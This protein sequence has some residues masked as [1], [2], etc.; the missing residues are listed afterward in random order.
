MDRR[1]FIRNI[2]W[3]VAAAATGG[4]AGCTQQS[5]EQTEMQAETPPEEKASGIKRYTAIG[6]TDL[7]MSDISMGCGGLD[8]VYV[9]DKALDVGINYFDTAPDYGNGNSESTLGKV[10]TESSKRQKAI[11]TTKFCERGPYGLHLEVNSPEEKYI[12]AVEGSLKRLNTDYIDFEMVHAIGERENDAARL[13]DS[14]MLSAYTKL[15][16]QGKVRYLSVSSHG[17][18]GMEEHLDA[19]ID[20]G[21]FDMI[22]PALN[23]ARFSRLG[24]ILAKAQEKGVGVVAMKT[25]ASAKQED[26]SRFE[27]ED[28]DLAQAAFKWVFAQPGITG[29]IITMKHTMDVEKYV[30]ASGKRFTPADQSLLDHYLQSIGHTYCRT[31]CGECLAA[32]PHAVAIPEILRYDM[33]FTAYREEDMALRSFHRLP[34]SQK[35]IPCENCIGSCASGCPYGLPVRDQLL[36]ASGRLQMV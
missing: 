32:C 6:N 5:G 23:F 4:V 33:Y 28:T 18:H 26:L 22:M 14:N 7:E 24:E 35:P 8:N 30:A 15:K 9:V 3:G 16:E 31:G 2:G 19:A 12:E 20:S 10:F 25:L 21:H 27:T 13:L 34:K 17:P 29:L 1:L 11:V 36:A